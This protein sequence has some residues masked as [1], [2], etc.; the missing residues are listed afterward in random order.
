MASNTLNNFSFT[1]SVRNAPSSG[2]TSSDAWNDTMAEIS[3]DLANISFEWN[4]K[5]TTIIDS[6]P[7]GT[8]DT[9]VNVF[10]TGLDGKTLWVDQ[11]V[12]SSSNDLTF[13]RSDRNRPA[14]V[15]EAFDTV[16]TYVN[17]QIDQTRNDIIDQASGLTTVQKNRIGA[18][19]F[20]NTQTSVVTSL[21]GKSENNRLNIIQVANDLYG[22]S[23]SLD[24]DG[25]KNL[26]TATLFDMVSS[27][28]VLHNSTWNSGT[29]VTHVGS[30]TATQDDISS[31][32]SGDDTYTA[33]PTHLRGDLNRIRNRF[34]VFMGT[35]WLSTLTSLYA[36]G[37]N[38]LEDL[39]AS[40]AGS[41]TKSATNPWGYRW[42]NVDGLETR[43]DAIRDF[44]GQDT[45]TDATTTFTSTA[46]INNGD[47]LELAIGKLDAVV[48]TGISFLDLTD[49]P[50]AFTGSAGK[51]AVVNDTEDA[52]I[53]IDDEV[54]SN[55]LTVSGDLTV[56]QDVE[57]TASG[58]GFIMSA[59]DGTRYR[60]QVTNGGGLT[61]TAI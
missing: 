22:D 8:L 45:H 49:S 56:S 32:H 36:G 5:L 58:N 33:A 60:L 50:A 52:L 21:D 51:R 7:C 15:K 2:P 1:F 13:F 20:D 35:G 48:A 41:A 18:N 6:L 27:L 3:N 16:Y 14:T 55:D 43:L 42:D 11:D 28:L 25:V 30:F 47:S 23:Y 38:N 61:T 57:I 34:R 24:G 4:T 59:P 53:F 31:S 17:T 12:V 44:T 40:T 26:S 37:A 54:Q 9:S 19:V 29:A 39:L 10:S 46:N